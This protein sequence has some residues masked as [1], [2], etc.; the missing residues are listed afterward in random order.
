MQEKQIY[1]LRTKKI[2]IFDMDGTLT[3]SKIAVD[4]EMACLICQLL[5]KKIV[6]IAS[7]ADFPQI[8]KQLLNYL[9]CAKTRFKNLFILPVN[10]GSLYKY[11]VNKWQ[12]VYENVFSIKEKIKVFTAFKK[13]LCDIYYIP[14]KK[15]YGK[16]IEERKSQI[17]FSALG[18]KATFIK[19]KEW[20]MKN[21]TRPQIRTAL[22][23]YLPNFNIYITGTT[24]IDITK[25]GIDKA[26]GIRQ[27]MKLLS[28]S[29]KEI[30]Y[31]AETFYKD[32]N[33]YVV[34]R[35]GVSCIKVKDQEETKTLIRLILLFLK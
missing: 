1:L 16:V 29:K 24:S 34:K 25:K 17:T 9:K 28:V 8:N 32:D 10:G 15:T 23:K 27:I 35:A 5:D 14:P 19:K 3:K 22:K 2:I 30:V 4:I 33:N 31:V 21:D 12:K 11:Q 7:G 20:N 6:I 26:Y 13:A 18:Q